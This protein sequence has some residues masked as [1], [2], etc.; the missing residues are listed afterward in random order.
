MLAG[1]P[2]P[3]RATLITGRVR[4][5]PQQGVAWGRLVLRWARRGFRMSAA[6]L[7]ANAG[8]NY[9]SETEGGDSRQA[10]HLCTVAGP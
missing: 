4:I 5:R 9:G 3:L 1:F 10:E 2:Y 6:D 7:D 8:R